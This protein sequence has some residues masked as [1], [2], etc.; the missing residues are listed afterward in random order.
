[1]ARRGLAEVKKHTPKDA[2]TSTLRQLVE[3]EL[4]LAR[5]AAR[6]LPAKPAYHIAKLARLVGQEVA[7]FR[8]KQ[9][10]LIKELGAE[11]DA[12]PAE[13]AAGHP[14]RVFQVTP[15]NQP[16]FATRIKELGDIE[17][18][19]PWKPIDLSMLGDQTISA[20]D[21]MALGD[22]VTADGV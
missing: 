18:T 16:D 19:L 15:E 8:D 17:V 7:I 11:R 12:T 1:M 21:I 5:L 10:A 3:A 6:Q 2:V 4:A 13:K 14:D 20:A 22:L 9:N